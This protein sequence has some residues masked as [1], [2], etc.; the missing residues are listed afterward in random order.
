MDKKEQEPPIPTNLPSIEALL[1]HHLVNTDENSKKT[2]ELLEHHLV[3]AE[4]HSKAADL[5]ADLHLETQGK[6]LEALLGL[7]TS[8]ENLHETV[9]KSKPEEPA[10]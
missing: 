7:K 3:K 5:R 9:K 1:E 8:I 6:I 2:H 10:N 4:E